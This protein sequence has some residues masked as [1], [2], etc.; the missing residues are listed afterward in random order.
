MYASSTAYLSH[1]STANSFAPVSKIVVNGIEYSGETHL[2]TH[3]K[4]QH[5]A[6]RMTGEFPAKTVD[7]EIWDRDGNIDLHGKEVSVYRGLRGVPVSIDFPENAY[8]IVLLSGTDNGNGTFSAV[9]QTRNNVQGISYF[10]KNNLEGLANVVGV[11]FPGVSIADDNGIRTWTIESLLVN[12]NDLFIRALVEEPFNIVVVD[13]AA[14]QTTETEWIP[15]GLFFAEEKDITTSKTGLSITFHGA[16]RSRL[17]DV[18]AKPEINYPTTLGAFVSKLCEMVG[19]PLE[20]SDFPLSDHALTEAP[21]APEETAARE[22]IARAAELGGCI[23]QISRDGGLR[24]ERPKETGRIVSAA[25]YKT[26]EAE[27]KLVPINSVALGH[28]DYEDALL[29]EDSDEIAANGKSEWLVADNPFADLHRESWLADV[30]AELFGMSIVPFKVLEF[31]DFFIFD[32]NDVVTITSRDGTSIK[33]AVLQLSTTAR[34][35][36]SFAALT[37]DGG[38]TNKNLAGGLRPAVKRVSLQVNHLEGTIATLAETINEQG[39]GFQSL[40][41]QTANSIMQSVAAQ[42][43]AGDYVAS[44]IEQLSDGI[45]FRFVSGQAAIDALTSEVEGN[46]S[47]LEE[48]IRFRGALI[49]LGKVGNDFTAELDNERLAFLENGTPIAYFSNSQLYI[50]DAQVTNSLYFEDWAIMPKSNG[51]LSIVY[52]A[53]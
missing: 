52:T 11:D 19:V 14:Q 15:M 28:A 38:K 1:I 37:Q 17:F 12:P 13:L 10:N 50:T 35:R 23:A 42:Y 27:P 53:G 21:N 34:L 51:N 49:E 30:A 33:T 46:Q 29:L 3:P 6:D 43:A 48:Y 9:L 39:D 20:T 41:E 45:D 40:V 36:S 31:L 16:D 4:I 24:I 26:L 5:N 44:I 2:K 18:A 7:F 47:L 22:L 8:G 25:H 32:L